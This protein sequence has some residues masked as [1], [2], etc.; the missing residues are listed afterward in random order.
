VNTSQ[1]KIA[2]IQIRILKTLEAAAQRGLPTKLKKRRR[3]LLA[4]KRQMLTGSRFNGN[5]L[6]FR[7]RRRLL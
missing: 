7:R 2:R 1:E 4:A 6:Q 3:R 5:Q